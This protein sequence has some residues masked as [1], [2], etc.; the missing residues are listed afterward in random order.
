MPTLFS[1]VA[2]TSPPSSKPPFA[3]VSTFANA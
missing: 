1:T 3:N 2:M